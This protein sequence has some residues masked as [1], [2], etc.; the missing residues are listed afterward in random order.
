MRVAITGTMGGGKSSVSDLLRKRGYTVYDTDKMVHAYYDKGGRLEAKVI[1]LFGASILNDEGVIDRT[2][3]SKRVFEDYA[4]LKRL[5]DLVYPEVSEH[6]QSL[7]ID[8]DT[9]LFFEVPMLFESG[10]ESLFDRIIM[11]S[12]P[13]VLRIERLKKRG[14]DE[15]EIKRRSK[16][17]LNPEI[18]RQKSDYFINNDGDLSALDD[19]INRVLEQIER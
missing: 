13:D 16:R 14:M 19:K 5:E 1:Q 11:V 15:E 4:M 2:K 8:N 17:H 12:A 10:L 9:L 7:T 3:I 18:K 6:I